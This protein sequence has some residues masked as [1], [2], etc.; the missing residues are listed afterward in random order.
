MSRILVAASPEPRGIV[1][2]I[3][4]GHELACAETMEQ[5]EQLL[6][7]QRFDLIMCTIAF[8]DSRMFDLL[9]LA[10]SKAEWQ[11]IPFVGA[12]VRPQVLR[13][14]AALKAAALTCQEL[15][16]AA[17]LDIASYDIAPEH[18]MRNAIER[19]IGSAH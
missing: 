2:R 9:K 5:A 7:G 13:T 8:D 10:K 4:A 3:L 12:R 18:E 16:A 11:A 17:F 14:A 1:E 6:H 15:G 19:L